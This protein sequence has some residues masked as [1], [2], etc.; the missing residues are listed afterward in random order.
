M[1]PYLFLT[2]TTKSARTSDVGASGEVSIPDRGYAC[3]ISAEAIHESLTDGS[4]VTRES[5]PNKLH[6]F[7]P[8]PSLDS[9]YFLNANRVTGEFYLK[10]YS[11]NITSVYVFQ[12]KELD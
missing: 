8:D 1:K 4:P 3:L 9:W 6:Q 11:E 10:L 7:D 12:K 5:P 2:V